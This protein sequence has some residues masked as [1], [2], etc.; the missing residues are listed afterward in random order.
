MAATN[1]D[2]STGEGDVFADFIV[3]TKNLTDCRLVVTLFSRNG[4]IY[5]EGLARLICSGKTPSTVF[6]GRLVSNRL[7]GM[8]AGDK[9]KFLL[10]KR[11]LF[12]MVDEAAK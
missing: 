11:V 12:P 6:T 10:T 8:Q 5:D 4:R 7:F 9:A 1:F 3:T 2:P